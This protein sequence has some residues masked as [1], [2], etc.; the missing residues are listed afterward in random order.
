MSQKISILLSI[1]ISAAL[2]L[3]ACTPAN[4]EEVPETGNGEFTP[5]AP[6]EPGDGDQLIAVG[7]QVYNQQCSSCHMPDGAGV[8]DTYPAL[9][10]NT[11]VQSQ[12]PTPVIDVVLH[13]REAM[14]PFE[15]VLTDE[16]VAGVITFIRNEWGNSAEPVSVDQVQALR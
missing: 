9:A 12:D 1:F 10:G 13:G 3:S 2:L 15:G 8:Q 6:A 14:P 16:E 4:G 5:G 7:E 11:F